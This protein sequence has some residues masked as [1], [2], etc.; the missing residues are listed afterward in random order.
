MLCTSCKLQRNELHPQKSKLM[1]SVILYLCQTC[2]DAKREPRY[3][4]ILVGRSRGLTA[5]SDYINNRKYCGK[6][7]LA[8]EIMT[9]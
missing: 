6:E 5:I 9:S 7:I 2:I 3:I 8:R 4:I 1:P